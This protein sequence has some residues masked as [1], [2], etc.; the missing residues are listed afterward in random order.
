ME[1]LSFEDF[2]NTRIKPKWTPIDYLLQ[3]VRVEPIT[4]YPPKPLL[5][6]SLKRHIVENMGGS[7]CVL[8]IQKQLFLSDVNPQTSRLFIPFS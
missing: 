8:V 2:E 1:L 3:V 4:S 6:E 5:P 7:N